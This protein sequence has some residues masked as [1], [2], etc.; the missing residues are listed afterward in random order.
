MKQALRNLRNKKGFSLIEMLITLFIIAF[1]LTAVMAIFVQSIQTRGSGEILTNANAAA[2]KF[3]ES[4]YAKTLQDI[5]PL[6]T[7]LSPYEDLYKTFKATP[8]GTVSGAAAYVQIVIDSNGKCTVV[9]PDGKY[10]LPKL[11]NTITMTA[12]STTYSLV[13]DSTSFTGS[14][15][16]GKLVALIYGMDKPASDKVTINLVAGMEAYKYC[17]TSNMDFIDVKY[18]T[19]TIYQDGSPADKVLLRTV[20]EIYR[21]S[22]GK[23]KMTTIEGIIQVANTGGS[24]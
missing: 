16:A 18:A 1:V 7:T 21:D 10:M 11:V 5:L 13:C 12:A 24:S 9:G 2:Q 4:L 6:Q 17:T 23:E 3:T 15:P 8:Q 22:A 19:T 20:T 14:K